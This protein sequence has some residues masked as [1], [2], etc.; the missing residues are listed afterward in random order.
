MI[1]A[2][3]PNFQQ[4]VLSLVKKNSFFCL[5]NCIECHKIFNMSKE[6]FVF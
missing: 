2:E 1:L 5:E 6:S 4:S 3:A